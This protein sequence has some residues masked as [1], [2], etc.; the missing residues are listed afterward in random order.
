MF[1][2][3][4]GRVPV[5][6]GLTT[7]EYPARFAGPVAPIRLVNLKLLTV[8]ELGLITANADA[9]RDELARRLLSTPSPLVSSL[10][11]A[12]VHPRRR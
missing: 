8:A 5:L 6:V 9:G 12:S 1:V 3:A 4:A 10:T 11:R 2:N 7:P